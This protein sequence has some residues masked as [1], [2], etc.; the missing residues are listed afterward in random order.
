MSCEA[1]VVLYKRDLDEP[2]EGV[3]AVGVS[4]GEGKFESDIEMPLARVISAFSEAEKKALLGLIM[5]EGQ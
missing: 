1:N 4:V 3:S 2:Q 5:M